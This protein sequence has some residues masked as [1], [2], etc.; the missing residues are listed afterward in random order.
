MA[1]FRSWCT[2]HGSNGTCVVH[3]SCVKC[4]AVPVLHTS[5]IGPLCSHHAQWNMQAQRWEPLV[6]EAVLPERV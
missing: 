1:Q 5:S 2:W 4:G 6:D 3:R